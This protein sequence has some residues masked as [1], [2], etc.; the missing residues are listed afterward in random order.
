MEHK[1]VS[2]EELNNVM[3]FEHV[4]RVHNDGTVSDSPYSVGSQDAYFDLT[5]TED[6]TDQFDMSEGWELL[7]GFTG[8]YGYNGPVMH[9]SEYIGGGLAQHILETPGDYVVLEV[10]SYSSEHEW[11]LSTF[12]G[13]KTCA[14]CGLLPLDAEDAESFCRDDSPAGWA[15]AFKPL[16]EG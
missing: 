10:S 1:T 11:Q 3:E 2:T 8:Q 15:V 5:V 13:T 16:E 14:V 4:I 6:G 7:T 12:T 9:S